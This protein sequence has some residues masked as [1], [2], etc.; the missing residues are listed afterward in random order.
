MNSTSVQEA[1]TPT[2]AGWL[3]AGGGEARLTG[4]LAVRA[5]IAASTVAGYVAIGLTMRM[6]PTA[7][8]LVGIPI[9]IGFQRLIAKRP[10]R[11][12][13]LADAPPFRLD[14]RGI[15]LAIALELVP[16]FLLI[17]GVLTRDLW[18]S[19][20][21]LAA[22]AGAPVAAYAL[23]AVNR[24]TVRSLLLSIATAGAVGMGFFVL[25][26]IG[27]GKIGVLVDPLSTIRILVLSFLQYI[28]IVFVIEE[29]FFRGLLD[30][31]VR[32]TRAIGDR[33][34][35]LLVSALWGFW[36]L[37]LTYALTGLSTLPVL[38]VFHTV[39]GLLLTPWWRRS[40][41]LAVPGL[42]HALTDAVRNALLVV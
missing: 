26:A 9:M 37:P 10:I 19:A 29:V 11:A 17:A 27:T 24:A 4:S 8:L 2:G 25:A 39:L 5:A 6:D 13:W 41:N 30:P 1:M 33:R 16:V 35:A 32:G 22:I 36:H 31:F 40:G 15:L 21:A 3:K 28:P 23:R 18:S 12:L 20:Y 34:S 7:Y 42:T 14:R 38:L